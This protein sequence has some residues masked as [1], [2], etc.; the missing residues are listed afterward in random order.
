MSTYTPDRW[1]VLE[2]NSEHGKIQKVFAGWY[3]G[4]TGS[5][6]WK[7]NSGITKVE[8][9]E[10]RY[11]FVGETGS[12]YICYKTCYGMSL[13]MAGVL[14]GWRS[15]EEYGSKFTIGIVEGYDHE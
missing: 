8:E 2:M 9:F 1:V 11:E 5:D 7:L 4:F 12:V 13:Y 3:G 6:S 14:M 10:D 15:A